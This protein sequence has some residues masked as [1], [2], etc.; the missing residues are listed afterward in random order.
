VDCKRYPVSCC[1]QRRRSAENVEDESTVVNCNRELTSILNERDIIEA[2]L[3]ERGEALEAGDEIAIPEINDELFC[4]FFKFV[5]PIAS[6][7]LGN[8]NFLDLT[9]DDLQQEGA[10]KILLTIN[11]YNLS[12]RFAPWGY[13]VAWRCCIDVVKLRFEEKLHLR[14]DKPIE[15]IEEE[16]NLLLFLSTISTENPEL[17]MMMKQYHLI[18]DDE[19]VEKRQ[20]CFLEAVRKRNDPIEMAI[21]RYWLQGVKPKKISEHTSLTMAD[22]RKGIRRLK[23]IEDDCKECSSDCA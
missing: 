14:R 19:D 3:G 1:I 9:A 11:S 4:L 20:D 18:D 6:Y 15:L 12:M 10:Y 16:E 2:V 23:R 8:N 21:Y 13:T 22:I 17:I 5:E 7:I